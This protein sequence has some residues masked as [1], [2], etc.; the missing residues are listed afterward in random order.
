[1]PPL[2]LPPLYVL[3][4]D[5]EDNEQ[6]GIIPR[7]RRRVLYLRLRGAFPFRGA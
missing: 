5:H 1:M 3:N 7:T 6:S 4:D 2:Y